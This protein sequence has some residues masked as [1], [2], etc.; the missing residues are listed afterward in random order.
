M[1]CALN[2]PSASVKGSEKVKDLLLF[3]VIVSSAYFSGSDRRSVRRVHRR[4][5]VLFNHVKAEFYKHN[6]AAMA[7]DANISIS[8]LR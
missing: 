6:S 5:F 8:P 7:S 4:T 3:S 2:K 1:K